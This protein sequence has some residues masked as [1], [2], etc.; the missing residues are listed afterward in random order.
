MVPTAK[1]PNT[2]KRINTSLIEEGVSLILR[3]MNIDLRDRNYIDTPDRYARFILE[4]FGH[5]ETEYATFPEDFTDFILLRRHTMYSLCPHHLIPVEFETSVAYIPKKEVLGLSKLVRVLDDVNCEPLL[6]ERFTK[7]V[8]ETV[9]DWCD[10]E[11]VACLV[12]GQHGCTK[13][14]GVRSTGRFWTY[15]LDGEFKTDPELARR[16]FDLCLH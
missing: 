10:V 9:K 5:K 7:Q 6:Q 1:N 16:F 13:I 14:R 3:G 15:R 11:G 8:I 4:M 2:R 12:N